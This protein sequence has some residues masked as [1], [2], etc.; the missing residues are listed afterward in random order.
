MTRRSLRPR[1]LVLAR[2]AARLR[3]PATG[4]HRSWYRTLV[5][6]A[7]LGGLMSAVL[8]FGGAP[9]A[10]ADGGT[11]GSNNTTVGSPAPDPAPGGAGGTGYTGQ[12]GSPGT[13]NTTG[14]SGGG[15][16]GG[17]AGGGNGG[18]GGGGNDSAEGGGSGGGGGPAGAGVG[19][20]APSAARAPSLRR[21]RAPRS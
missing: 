21:A 4:S 10:L 15:G 11:G 3:T 13:T 9:L 6:G 17:G 1:L 19:F 7:V 8:L 16:G 18:A 12:A 5:G 20:G 2:T 14:G